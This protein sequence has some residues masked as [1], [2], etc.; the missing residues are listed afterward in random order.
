MIKRFSEI[1]IADRQ[2]IFDEIRIEHPRLKHIRECTRALMHSTKIRIARD[3]ERRAAAKGRPIKSSELWVLP[4]VGPSGAMKSTSMGMIIDEIYADKATPDNEIPV[5]IVTLRGVK[6]PKALQAAILERLDPRQASEL[7]SLYGTY[8][9]DKVNEAI[10]TQARKYRTSILVIDEAHSVLMHDAGKIGP[11]MARCIHGLINEGI[12]SIVLMG[13]KSVNNLFIDSELKSRKVQDMSADLSAFDIKNGNDRGYFFGFIDK[14]E[15]RMVKKEV[16]S[17]KLG[18]VGNVEYRAH[19]YDMAEGIPG[20]ISRIIRLAIR[21]A[22][23]SGRDYLEWEDVRVCFQTWNGDEGKKDR[24]GEAPNY[25]PFK[26]GIRQ[27]TVKAVSLDV[28]NAQ[29]AKLAR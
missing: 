11:Q 5:L 21:Q 28:K 24:E 23:L 2:A 19:L 3:D 16:V 4:I 8:H 10:R 14:I 18:L 26:E 17:K 1:E 20:T 9:E 7:R 22:M 15:D 12:F 13:T 25:D 27:A 29:Q 6:T